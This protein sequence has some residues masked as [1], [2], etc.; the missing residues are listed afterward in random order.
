[1]ER[2]PIFWD[3]GGGKSYE[4][5]EE[6]NKDRHCQILGGIKDTISP[7][8]II[9]GTVPLPPVDYV[10][11]CD[12]HSVNFYSANV[13]SFIGGLIRKIAK[14]KTINTL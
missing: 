7:S 12:E 4:K 2:P 9:G 5:S 13:L 8:Q 6:Q 11:G 3:L 10:R 14:T 1:M